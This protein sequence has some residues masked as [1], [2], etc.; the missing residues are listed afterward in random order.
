MIYGVYEIRFDVGRKILRPKH[1]VK[2]KI[3]FRKFK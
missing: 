1:V 3:E 2:R